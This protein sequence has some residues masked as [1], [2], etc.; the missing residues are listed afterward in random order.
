MAVLDW[1]FAAL[2]L[3]SM[4]VGAWRGL[5]YEVLSLA[6]WVAAFLAAQWL[7]ADV[8]ARLPL[9]EAGETMRYAA[10]F[11]LVFV[12]SLFVCGFLAWLTKKLV[13]AVG[14][15][16]VDRTLGAAF[17]VLRG[18]LVLLVLVVMAGLMQL[19]QADWWQESRGAVLLSDLLQ[20]LRPVLPEELGRH[21]PL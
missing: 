20:G 17:G 2:L 5:V 9:G 12:G 11:I 13:E 16:P 21:L 4:L 18:V 1:I 6:G 14:L 10:G 15:R 19:H 7:A 3:V 8:A